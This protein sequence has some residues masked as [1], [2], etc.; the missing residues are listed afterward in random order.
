MAT[1][2]DAWVSF[3]LAVKIYEEDRQLTNQEFN[4][5]T[6]QLRRQYEGLTPHYRTM[7]LPHILSIHE[8]S[9]M[10]E[11]LDT[12]LA[13]SA[14]QPISNRLVASKRC[15]D[16]VNEQFQL[17]NHLF[18]A[19]HGVRY[20]FN[21]HDYVTSQV[22][23]LRHDSID[24]EQNIR[25][26]ADDLR[27]EH[28]ASPSWV[29]AWKFA[30]DGS[31]GRTSLWVKQDSSGLIN[32]RCVIKDTVLSVNSWNSKLCFAK[33]PRYPES[34]ERTM[35]TEVAAHAA[36]RPL[37]GSDT[38]IRMRNWRL[39]SERRMYRLYLE[40]AP[41]GDLYQFMTWYNSEMP[42]M[43]EVSAESEKEIAAVEHF[44]SLKAFHDL[45]EAKEL[46]WLPEPFIWACFESLAKAG[47]LMEQGSLDENPLT[48]WDLIVH[49]DLKPSNVFLGVPST[50]NF[51]CYP[52]AKLGDFGLAQLFP[53]EDDGD[54]ERY[55]G[56]GT[57]YCRAPEQVPLALFRGPEQW[58]SAT[59]VWGIGIIIWGLMEL[60]EGDH[61]LVYEK[62]SRDGDS[63]SSSVPTLRPSTEQRYSKGLCDLVDACTEFRPSDRPS[64]REV[65]NGIHKH[66]QDTSTGRGVGAIRS[67]SKNDRLSF[68]VQRSFDVKKDGWPLGEKLNHWVSPPPGMHAMPSPPLPEDLSA[69]EY[70]IGGAE[71][72][73]LE[74]LRRDASGESADEEMEIDDSP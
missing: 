31:F 59:N 62:G 26:L 36:L 44:D 38:I 8:L 74:L 20:P 69:D 46:K 7:I 35:P 28:G 12:E 72:T 45:R 56:R 11:D 49:F 68:V 61:R 33:D 2:S 15:L 40:F 54:Y 50:K 30:I 63:R 18:R 57:V 21:I 27:R 64:F 13:A 10:R 6:S 53:P 25:Q 1:E 16:N 51:T 67:S 65:L 22:S 42:S 14:E 39:A 47:L 58:T 32:D 3:Q 23:S 37:E 73:E 55:C 52:Q 9:S 48:R 71:G 5:E 17:Y 41:R 34:E 43:R 19:L 60:E 70:E 24:L 66:F 4:R 29:G